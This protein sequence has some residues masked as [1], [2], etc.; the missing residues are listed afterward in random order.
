[1][2]MSDDQWTLT[3]CKTNEGDRYLVPIL[4]CADE[5]HLYTIPSFAVVQVKL[6]QV[7]YQMQCDKPNSGRVISVDGFIRDD[8]S[9]NHRMYPA[10]LSFAGPVGM[11]YPACYVKVSTACTDSHWSI[12]SR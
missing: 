5:I 6:R 7:K 11:N 9:L 12:C 3:V 8:P 2:A 10:E 4:S 1:M